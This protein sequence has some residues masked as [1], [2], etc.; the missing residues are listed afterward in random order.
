MGNFKRK[1]GFGGKKSFG[2]KKKFGSDRGFRK[3]GG[4]NDRQMFQA[5]CSEC[6]KRCDLPFQPSGNRAVFCSIC[7]DKKGP[8]SNHPAGA[9]FSDESSFSERKSASEH[10]CESY[11]KD[12]ELLNSK[13]D[14]ILTMLAEV[15]LDRKSGGDDEDSDELELD[16]EEEEVVVEKVKK[17]A[18]KAETKKAVTKKTAKAKKTTE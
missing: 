3:S 9:R 5:T 15:I 16:E 6:G 8:D 13:L 4:R 7:F 14:D 1:E 2:D 11:K 10:C 12:F 18:K 17:T